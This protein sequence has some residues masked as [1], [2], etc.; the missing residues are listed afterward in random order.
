MVPL[1]I[2]G[3][4]MLGFAATGSGSE[5]LKSPFKERDIMTVIGVQRTRMDADDTG[6][7]HCDRM[8]EVRGK[9]G[10]RWWFEEGAL[11]RIHEIVDSKCLLGGA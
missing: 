11:I 8:I 5:I 2:G 3:T 4:V 7:R 6:G 9:T 10:F 1:Q